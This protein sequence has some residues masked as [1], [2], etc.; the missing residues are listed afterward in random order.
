MLNKRYAGK[1]ESATNQRR[2]QRRINDESTIKKSVSLAT[3]EQAHSEIEYKVPKIVLVN[4]DSVIPFS[5]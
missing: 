1:D 3:A 5:F 2:N 4:N